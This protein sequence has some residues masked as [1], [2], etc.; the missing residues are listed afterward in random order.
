MKDTITY[1]AFVTALT[2]KGEDIL[3]TLTP[4]KCHL[5]HMA[6]GISGEAGEVLDE[7]KKHV[8]YDKPLNLTKVIKELGDVEFYLEGLRQGLGITREMIIVENEVKLSE[9]YSSGTYS[10]QQAISRKDIS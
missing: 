4:E 9:R 1:P 7:I 5:Q 2:K 10:D 6:M 3:K 8:A